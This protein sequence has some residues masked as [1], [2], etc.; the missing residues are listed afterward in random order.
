MSK[1]IEYEKIS[2]PQIVGVAVSKKYIDIYQAEK[3][4]NL[5]E[6]NNIFSI[7]IC[8]YYVPNNMIHTNKLNYFYN[9]PYLDYGFSLV[10]TKQQVK[11]FAND[12]EYYEFDN[13]IPIKKV[14][15]ETV[16]GNNTLLSFEVMT[17]T[18]KHLRIN[19]SVS[20]ASV[21]RTLLNTKIKNKEYKNEFY[22]LNRKN[23]LELVGK[24]QVTWKW[25][26]KCKE[27]YKT[28]SVSKQDLQIGK[29]YKN[30]IGKPAIF[31]GY[32]ST[33]CYRPVYSE[34]IT[35]NNANIKKEIH[36]V[37]NKLTNIELATMWLNVPAYYLNN[38][39]FKEK[40]LKALNSF[41]DRNL[42]LG[43]YNAISILKK[44][45]FIELIDEIPAYDISA[46]TF[47]AIKNNAN[48]D[49]Q[50]YINFY[51]IYSNLNTKEILLTKAIA[52]I[53]KFVNLVPYG[54]NIETNQHFDNWLKN[55]L[56]Q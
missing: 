35:N 30:K 27:R 16:Y 32:V 12:F 50:K 10:E 42:N 40:N 31:I 37:D 3:D 1:I 33:M 19:K 17:T 34:K 26:L 6:N 49:L 45:N 46:A 47:I 22:F 41:V 21:C 52:K 56:K 8:Y 48:S 13:S 2:L 20:T 44:H 29:I 15:I 14:K 53:S 5:F 36:L 9:I 54:M 24:D 23:K 51:K 18:G 39:L 7:P 25:Y 38:A 28:H 55:K 4:S 11:L 43:T